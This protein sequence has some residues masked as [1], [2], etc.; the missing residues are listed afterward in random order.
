MS[1]DASHELMSEALSAQFDSFIAKP[2]GIS[3][4]RHIVEEV[5]RR[6][7]EMDDL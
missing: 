2:F 7:Y 1:A 6:H 4:L 3:A 5:L